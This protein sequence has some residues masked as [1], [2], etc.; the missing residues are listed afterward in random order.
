MTIN[1]LCL[2]Q[3]S[4]L[5]G[6]DR[7][8]LSAVEALSSHVATH[9]IVP[10][11]GDLAPLL[12]K[13]GSTVSYYP[14]GVLR[15]KSFRRPLRYLLEMLSA[16]KHYY[17][18]YKAHDIVYINTT[19][20][21]SALIAAS[22]YRGAKKTFFCHVREIPGSKSIFI[23]RALLRLS[24]AKLIFNSKATKDAFG[25]KGEVIYNGVEEIALP[26][27]IYQENHKIKILLIGRINTWKGQSFFLDSLSSLAV[28]HL[29]KLD[30]RI[31]GSAFEGYEYLETE[32]HQKIKV[33]R[34]S[35]VVSLIPFST[36][37]TEHYTWAD[38][39]V[40]PSIKPEPFGRVAIEAFSM[41]LP[42]IAAGHG[43]LVEIVCQSNNG[44]I[45]EPSSSVALSEVLKN[46]PHPS[47]DNYR[48]LSVGA[49][50]TYRA[51]FSLSQYAENIAKT[52]LSRTNK[53]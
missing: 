38:Y 47:S 20:M 35:G 21:F 13:S 52:V 33:S 36:D 1:I 51:K 40:V 24:G 6:S 8:F 2:H 41:G 5:Y 53:D 7:S 46:I 3:G 31:V 37:P 42:V 22:L 26:A 4:E 48:D 45:F 15:K 49:L 27:I 9:C 44:F 25:L 29:S 19:V 18:Y 39:V 16:V 32:L 10:S 34:L 23:F 14:F 11:P 50:N 43:G 12:Q 28:E 30:V 17:I